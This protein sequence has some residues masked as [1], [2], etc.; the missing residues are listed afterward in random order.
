[1]NSCLNGEKCSDAPESVGQSLTVSEDS[2]LSVLSKVAD[3]ANFSSDLP[4]FESF[5]FFPFFP[6]FFGRFS[7]CLVQQSAS[8]WPSLPQPVHLRF[9]FESL[10]DFSDFPDNDVYNA[11]LTSLP[12]DPLA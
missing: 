1:M 9:R 7:G 2:E 11:T 6:F 12:L 8:T 4:S 5:P 10:P 3:M